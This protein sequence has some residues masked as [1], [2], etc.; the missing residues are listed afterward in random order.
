M[1]KHSLLSELSIGKD[2]NY[3]LLRIL[4]ALA[5]LV[6]HS[7]PLA[8]GTGQQDPIHMGHGMT[9]GTVG[10][11][12]FFIASGFLV[13][14]SLM[15]RQSAFDFV[16][17]RF[18][19]IFPGLLVMNLIM[20]FIVGISVTTLGALD[21][22][23]SPSVYWHLFANSTLVYRISYTL[24]GVF[25]DAPY[26]SVINGSLWTMP[27]E[28]KMYGALLASWLMLRM[29]GFDQSRHFAKMCLMLAISSGAVH[30]LGL[31]TPLPAEKFTRLFFMFFSGAA[32]FLFRDRIRL[33][34]G[35][36][37]CWLLACGILLWQGQQLFFPC[38]NLGVAYAAFCFAYLPDGVIRRFNTLGDFSYGVYIYAWPTQQLIAVSVPGISPTALALTSACVV[39]L[40]ASLSWYWVEKPALKQKE[41]LMGMKLYRPLKARP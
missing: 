41:R 22:L 6:A 14:S 29:A 12:L 32:F 33:K 8:L 35:V 34:G 37:L 26:A 5:V 28:L 31:Y 13:C 38:Y 17:S 25:I 3:N 40:L 9:P 10:V 39:G 1:S 36:A 15:S 11:D 23:S 19:R 16:V 30:L 18:L 21:Y 20:V 2:N 7:F 24:P 4:A 27:V